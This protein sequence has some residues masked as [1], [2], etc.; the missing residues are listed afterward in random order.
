VVTVEQSLPAA[1]GGKERDRCASDLGGGFDVFVRDR[2]T[3]ECDWARV[4]SFTHVHGQ[5]VQI[6]VD[7]RGKTT[8]ACGWHGSTNLFPDDAVRSRPHRCTVCGCS[9]AGPVAA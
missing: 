2:S 1:G 5:F 4:V 3:G 6:A 9:P 8:W 7:W